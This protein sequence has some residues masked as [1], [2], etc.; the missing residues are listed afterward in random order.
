MAVLINCHD[1]TCKKVARR[2]SDMGVRA[3]IV[4]CNS[5]VLTS[6]HDP[7]HSIPLSSLPTIVSWPIDMTDLNATKKFASDVLS[8]FGSVD[9]LLINDSPDIVTSS[10]YY[11]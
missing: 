8:I 7:V 4:A 6:C 5:A 2:L 9:I 1:P 11:I 3:V 10:G